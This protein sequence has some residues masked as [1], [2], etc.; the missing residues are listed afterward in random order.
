MCCSSANHHLEVFCFSSD[1]KLEQPRGSGPEMVHRDEPRPTSSLV[2]VKYIRVAT[3][4]ARMLFSQQKLGSK[5]YFFPSVLA[6]CSITCFAYSLSASRRYTLQVPVKV[7]SRFPNAETRSVVR[8]SS[9]AFPPSW[10][11]TFFDTFAPQVFLYGA[12]ACLKSPP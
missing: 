5:Q 4:V 11:V 12:F 7:P 3:L 9:R 6:K 10:V 1:T 2:I 8:S